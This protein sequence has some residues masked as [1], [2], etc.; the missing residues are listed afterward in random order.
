M[1]TATPNPTTREP[2]PDSGHTAPIRLTGAAAALYA[3]LIK[4][5]AD[6]AATAAELALAARVGRSTASKVLVALEQRGLAVRTP[7]GFD[8]PRR[9]ADLWHPAPSPT[10]AN[11]SDHRAHKPTGAPA[12]PAEL[13]LHSTD[14]QQVDASCRA[15]EDEGTDTPPAATTDDAD[16]GEG[17]VSDSAPDGASNSGAPDA[18]TPHVPSEQSPAPLAALIAPT[19]KQRLAPGGLRQMVLDYLQTHPD[20]AFTATKIS[21]LIDKS[22]GA[23]ANAL[24]KLL[25]QGLAE[26]VTD[27]PRTYRLAT[28]ESAPTQ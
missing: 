12:E 23:I 21:R 1:S 24:H 19:H 14:R 18:L 7:G 6:D 26:Q 20:Q 15:P 4:L 25:M 5:T 8:G 22:S 9:I 11:N 16:P 28:T 17:N 3:E 2:Q 10:N 13:P 27:Q